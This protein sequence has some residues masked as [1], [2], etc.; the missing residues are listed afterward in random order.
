MPAAEYFSNKIAKGE[1]A[2]DRKMK[3]GV[4]LGV[5]AL[6]AAGGGYCYFS[7]SRDTPEYAFQL[8]EESIINHD[9][10]EFY[11]IV[12][13]DSVL[14]SS[15][16]GLVEGLTDS[17]KTMT[18][19]AKESIKNFTQ[20]LRV[21][22]LLS[23]KS[24][25]DSYIETGD[26]HSQENI[27]VNE[28]IRRTGFDK[29][30]YRGVDSVITNASNDSATAKIKIYQ[31]ELEKEFTL[32]AAM[33]KTEDGWQIIRLENLNEFLDS[34]NQNRLAQLDKYLEQVVEITTRHDA[35][36]LDAEQKHAAIMALGSLN[37]QSNRDGLKNLMLNVFKKDWE[38][39]KQE[40][41]SLSAPRNA[42]TLQNLLLKVCDLEISYA[43]DIAQWTADSKS[44]TLKAAEEK[45]RQAQ[46][47]KNE[48]NLFIE[49]MSN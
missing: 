9:K 27:G 31:P 30:Q 39:R 37:Q 13:V 5:A 43:E 48:I 22:L 17:D 41:F 19:D 10:E 45:H 42:E 16:S 24:A 47:L 6:I 35:A 4:G 20:M 12:K 34:I 46:T 21:P 14:E 25:I 36:I 28:I 2:L 29:I 26:F 44:T 7:A 15:Y 18:D 49:R 32:E 38:E 11:K 1:V 23:L 8:V 40:L 33:I 3:I